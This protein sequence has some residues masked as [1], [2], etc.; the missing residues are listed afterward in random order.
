VGKKEKKAL[1]YFLAHS[2]DQEE[3]KDEKK[4][5]KKNKGSKIIS[6]KV[7]ALVSLTCRTLLCINH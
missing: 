6:A 2:L 3:K 7:E 1:L 5:E 4:E